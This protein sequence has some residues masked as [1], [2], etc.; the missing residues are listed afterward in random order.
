MQWYCSGITEIKIHSPQ[1]TLTHENKQSPWT[2][3]WFR[4]TI[5]T[6][7]SEEYYGIV[8]IPRSRPLQLHE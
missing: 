8:F 2:D 3:D 4:T 6:Q 1:L 7:G 5:P